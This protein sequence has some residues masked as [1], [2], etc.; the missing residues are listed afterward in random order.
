MEL[1]KV[2]LM[3]CLEG[4]VVFMTLLM[5]LVKLVFG[6]GVGLQKTIQSF[7]DISS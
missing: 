5:T 1:M 7:P 2:A 6:G 4:L 3:V